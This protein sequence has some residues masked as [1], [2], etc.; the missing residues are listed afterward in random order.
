MLITELSAFKKLESIQT[1][2]I[3]RTDEG[4]VLAG[5]IKHKNR[6]NELHIFSAAPTQIPNHAGRNQIQ[7]SSIH[8]NAEHTKNKVNKTIT[9]PKTYIRLLPK[10]KI[11]LKHKFNLFRNFFEM[12]A[13]FLFYFV[14]KV[15]H[16]CFF[17]NFS[18]QISLHETHQIGHMWEVGKK[19][20]RALRMKIMTKKSNP[21]ERMPLILN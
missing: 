10:Q 16:L 9:Q 11:E 15:I 19:Q 14:F 20:G 3:L 2:I 7:Q 4:S 13:Q 8:E 5:Q 21:N 1:F 17:M 18:L 6:S 12:Q